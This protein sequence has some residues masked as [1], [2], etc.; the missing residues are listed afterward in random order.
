M[1]HLLRLR[2]RLGAGGLLGGSAAIAAG[3]GGAQ[4]VGIAAQPI[5]TRLYTPADYGAF[6]VAISALF[7]VGSIASLRYE[8][9]I[10]LARDDDEAA[11]VLGLAL[12][13]A[14]GSSL[15]SALVLWIVGPTLLSLAGASLLAAY[16]SS[17]A[18][19]QFAMGANYALTNWAVRNKNYAAIS[20]N[21]LDQALVQ[22]PVHIGLGL[23]GMGAPGLLVGLLAGS[24]ASLPRLLRAAWRTH[25]AS[26]RRVTADGMRVA[27]QR[28]RRF[29][30]FAAP[31]ALVFALGVRAPVILLVPLYGAETGGQYFLAERLLYLPLVLVASSVGHVFNAE[32]AAHARSGDAAALKTLFVNTTWSLAKVGFLP[33]VALAAAAPF[34]TGFIFGSAWDE[35]GLFMALL[36]PMFYLAFVVTTTGQVLFLLERQPLQ[37]I[38]ELVR[39]GLLAAPVLTAALLD[40]PA[41]AAVAALSVGGC[42]SYAVYWIISWRAV[43]EELGG[44]VERTRRETE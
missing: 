10:T 28:Y 33:A 37:L 18:A 35:A 14:V 17:L 31:S 6:S 41:I 7:V 24:L 2:E 44:S 39:L 19:G 12:V 21:R 9:A 42:V 4:L 30:I 8:F 29:P 26:L 32:G 3:T 25:S 22:S 1:I 38:R 43:S 27:A 5:L 23:L 16:A 11:N 20:L 34:A 13:L 36:M 40:L 15:I